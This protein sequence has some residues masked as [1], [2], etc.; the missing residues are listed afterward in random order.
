MINNILK[1]EAQKERISEETD[2]VRRAVDDMGFEARVD[3]TVADRLHA[4]NI[5]RTEGTLFLSRDEGE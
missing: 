4:S 3:E 1:S 2:M 5:A